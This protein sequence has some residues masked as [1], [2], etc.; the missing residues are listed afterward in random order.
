MNAAELRQR[1]VTGIK[2]LEISITDQ[3]I[4][5]LVQYVVMLD[6]WN[7]AYNLTAIRDPF[8]M[9]D[10][11]II[12]S[13]SILPFIENETLIDVGSGPGLPGIPAAI[14]KPE[15]TVITMDSNG[16]K[17]RFQNQVKA[18]LSLNNLQ[19]EHGRVES[20]DI[21]PA[22]QVI[23]RAFASLEDMVTLCSSLCSEQGRFLAMKGIYPEQEIEA[24]PDGYAV[25]RSHRLNVPGTDGERHLL[26]IERV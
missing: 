19:V 5:L 20:M 17:T 8:A 23:S 15:I 21:A 6:K 16:K 2:P 18:E 12:D 13:L 14:C 1:L 9:V 7:K 24:L 10:R 3:Q 22:N 25:S 26:V 4:D 11:H